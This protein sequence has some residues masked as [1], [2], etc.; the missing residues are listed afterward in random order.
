MTEEITDAEMEAIEAISART[1]IHSLG[2]QWVPFADGQ[3]AHLVA[4][5]RA[6]RERLAA[7]EAVCE[8]IG[9]AHWFGPPRTGKTT[10]AGAFD[11]WHALAHPEH[12]AG[13][14]AG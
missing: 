7:A 9:H 10:V 14:E 1:S 3:F 2:L 6:T 13:E 5:L 4:S 12:V 8:A 11:A